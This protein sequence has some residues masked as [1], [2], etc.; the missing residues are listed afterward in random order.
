MFQD[1]IRGRGFINKQQMEEPLSHEEVAA[2]VRGRHR[3]NTE[4]KEW[5]ICYRPFRNYW[6]VLL[7]TVNKRIFAMPVPRVIPTKIVAQYE[8]EE[9][10]QRA[11]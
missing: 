7:L 2:C 9:E 11:V 1:A 8:Q 5:E 4:L 3:W 6:I 10:Y